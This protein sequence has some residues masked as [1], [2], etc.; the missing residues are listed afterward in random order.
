MES[1]G[2]LIGKLNRAKRVLSDE[3]FAR[4]AWPQAVG[5]KIAAHTSVA[6]LVRKTL[7]VE[8]EDMVWQRQINTLRPQIVAALAKVAGPSL[9]DDIELR[10]MTP[11]QEPKRAATARRE[12]T[13]ADEADS[14]ADS[15][16][17]RLYK[18]SRKKATA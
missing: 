11:R 4:A 10:P 15:Q 6:K 5:K 12:L 14:I 2:R 1:A 9:V 3:D 16:L 7:V 8:V 13:A 17:R 18:N